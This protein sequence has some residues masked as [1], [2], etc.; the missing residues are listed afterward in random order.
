MPSLR[1]TKAPPCPEEVDPQAWEAEWVGLVVRYESSSFLGTL[2]P[3]PARVF[4]DERATWRHGTAA[5]AMNVVSA[6]LSKYYWV[7]RTAL[8]FQCFRPQLK[9][10]LMREWLQA[11]EQRCREKFAV[12]E[13]M[14]EVVER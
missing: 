13:S 5:D 3:L 9:R 2:G 14:A 1:F 6:E 8:L 10:L 12:P 4:C 11:P 7:P